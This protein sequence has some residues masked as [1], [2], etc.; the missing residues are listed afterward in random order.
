[1]IK[2][3]AFLF[4][5]SI[6]LTILN[7]VLSILARIFLLI[8]VPIIGIMILRFVV[9]SIHHAFDPQ[10]KKIYLEQQAAKAEEL[11]K[12]KEQEEADAEAK[13][14]SE[15]L[16]KRRKQETLQEHR[17]SDSQ[18][19][20]YT[21][22]IGKHGNES[23]AIRYGI[24][25]HEQKTKEY[26]YHTKGGERKRNP[27]RDE[28]FYEPA[29]SIKLQKTQKISKDL[30]EVILVDFRNRKARAIIEPGT[31]YVKTIYPLDEVWF[32]K[33]AALE[34]ALKG[35]NSFTLKELATFHIDKTVGI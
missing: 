9:R 6:I 29:N 21:Y 33:H 35:N 23:L 14:E 15:Q 13:A 26:W 1:M 24:A 30:Y 27:D 34:E 8:T 10:A 19:A 12:K 31:E 2:F 32:K 5:V 20:P 25:N 11:R 22:L 3:F 4:I 16:E 28:I 18:S 17:D 7:K